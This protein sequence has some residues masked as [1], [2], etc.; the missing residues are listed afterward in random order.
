[1]GSQ[2]FATHFWDEALFQD[3]VHIDD[4]PFLKN[5]KVAL[6]ILFSCVIC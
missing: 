3:V 5:A 6:G 4:L 2:D 1:V